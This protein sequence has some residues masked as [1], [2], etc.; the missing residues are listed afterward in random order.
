MVI[1][2]FFLNFYKQERTA[3]PY[4]IRPGDYARFVV[5]DLIKLE[6][7]SEIRPR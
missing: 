7:N 5:N 4:T 1:L 2:I 3:N 6:K